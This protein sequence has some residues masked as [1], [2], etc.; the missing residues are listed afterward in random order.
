M[1]RHIHNILLQ[2]SDIFLFLKLVLFTFFL[3]MAEALLAQEHHDYMMQIREME[4]LQLDELHHGPSV[5][6][7]TENSSGAGY[8]HVD[9]HN[10]SVV[11]GREGDKNE[12]DKNEGE[13]SVPTIAAGD[14]AGSGTTEK[15]VFSF[16]TITQV[17]IVTR[18]LPVILFNKFSL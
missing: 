9:T 14:A 12:S 16:A 17:R 7:G 15:T 11:D 4:L 1:R 2:F 10:P 5:S 8:S 13:S 18:I 3:S 6:E